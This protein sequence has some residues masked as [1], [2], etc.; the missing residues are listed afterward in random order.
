MGGLGQSKQ[1][2]TGGRVVLLEG[3]MKGEESKEEEQGE[4]ESEGRF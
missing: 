2:F 1:G 4:Q 3:R